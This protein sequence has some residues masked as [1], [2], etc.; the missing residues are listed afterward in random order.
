MSL[1]FTIFGEIF[2]YVTF[3]IIIIIFYSAIEGITFRLHAQHM[4]G[5]FLLPA[6]TRLGHDCQ[7]LLGPC[8]G[9]HVYT[10]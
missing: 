4:H 10:D 1:G 3:F 6:F 7:D 2:A 8:D 9:M 5:A